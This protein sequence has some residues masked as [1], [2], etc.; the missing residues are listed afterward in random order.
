MLYG[1]G[2]KLLYAYKNKQISLQIILPESRRYWIPYQYSSYGTFFFLSLSFH[3][4]VR[5][6]NLCTISEAFSCGILLVE[7]FSG[8]ACAEKNEILG[9]WKVLDFGSFWIVPFWAGFGSLFFAGFP[10][11]VPVGRPCCSSLFCSYLFHSIQ[12]PSSTSQP[13]SRHFSRYN[14]HT[15]YPLSSSS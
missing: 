3:A 5:W 15:H 1:L 4:F 14:S 6:G 12:N 8:I 11:F 7:G 2:S 9:V 13:N 10:F